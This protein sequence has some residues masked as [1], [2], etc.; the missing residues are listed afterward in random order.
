M[1]IMTLSE[2]CLNPMGPS[3]NGRDMNKTSLEC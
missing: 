2:A 1:V 3:D